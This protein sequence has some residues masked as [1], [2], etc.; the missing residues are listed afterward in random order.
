MNRAELAAAVESKLHEAA[1]LIDELAVSVRADLETVAGAV[2]GAVSAMIETV[3]GSSAA[4][5]AVA[6]PAADEPEQPAP[7][8]D[9]DAPENQ[10]PAAEQ[11]AP[12]DDPDAPSLGTDGAG[13]CARPA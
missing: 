2:S 6:A 3:G 8:D 13:N 5:V 9:P 7:S 12:S 4:P 10:P 11:T 1:D